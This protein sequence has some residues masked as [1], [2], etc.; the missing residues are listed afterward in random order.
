MQVHASAEQRTSG[1][2]YAPS[3]VQRSANEGSALHRLLG[4]DLDTYVDTH[5]DAYDQA[6]KKWAE[7]S[8]EEWKAG[9][10]GTI[11]FL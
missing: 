2:V 6:K 4:Q 8:N 1:P 10:D 3:V 9:A 11:L 7:C 5:V